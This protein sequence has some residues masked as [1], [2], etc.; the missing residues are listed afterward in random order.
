MAL[1]KLIQTN[2]LEPVKIFGNGFFLHNLILTLL[3]EKKMQKNEKSS[4]AKYQ[5][6]KISKDNSYRKELYFFSLEGLQDLQIDLI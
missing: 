4:T 5:K 3:S 2:I 1:Q 6:Q